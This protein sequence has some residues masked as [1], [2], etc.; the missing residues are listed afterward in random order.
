MGAF[1]L[2]DVVD[3]CYWCGRKATSAEHVPPKCIFPELKDSEGINY[4]KNLITVPS[5]DQHNLV[6]TKDDEYLLLLLVVNTLRNEVGKQQF[7]TKLMRL[8]RQKPW[9]VSN[10]IGNANSIH[11]F[12]TDDTLIGT[13]KAF[14]V[15]IKR[16]DSIIEHV[17]RALW[18]HEYGL[19]FR[20]RFEIL[21]NGLRYNSVRSIHKMYAV[22]EKELFRIQQT[23]LF[24]GENPD[25]FRYVFTYGR[26]GR[27]H[28]SMIFY[29]FQMLFIVM[30][31]SCSWSWGMN[32]KRRRHNKSLELSP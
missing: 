31:A 16:Y 17:A 27:V 20:G 30:E 11:M 15:D 14:Q 13:G 7:D 26:K 5:C 24:K 18:F 19:R 32:M 4:R 6:K 21:I 1:A 23:L 22:Y 25:V 29:G 8:I 10:V 28:L 3:E 12:D 2:R 9:F